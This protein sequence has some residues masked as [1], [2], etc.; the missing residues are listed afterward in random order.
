MFREITLELSLKPFKQNDTASMERICREL[1]SA[2]APLLR[3][4]EA[5]SVMLWAS[6]GSEI[7]DYAG[8]MDTPF[9]WCQYMG[10]ANLPDLKEGEPKYTSL[11]SRRQLYTENPPVFTYGILRE[12]VAILKR[13]GKRAFPEAHITVGETFDIGPEFAESD[14][15]Y[16]RH[17]EICSGTRLDGFGFVDATAILSPDTTRYA[18][19]PHGIPEGTCFGTFL[20]RQS[21][22]FLRDMGFDY[23]WLSNGLGFS[24]NPWDFTG[25]IYDGKQYYP[26]K[27]SD[28][29]ERVFR[30]WTLFRDACSYPLRVRGTNNTAG[31]DYATDGVPLHDIYAAGLDITPPPNSPWA[32]INDNFGLEMVGHMTRI[33]E[34]PGEDFMFRYYLHDPWWVNSPWYDRYDGAPTDIYLPMAVTRIREDGGVQGAERLQILSVDN[35]YGG[36]PACTVNEVIPH[37]LKAEKDLPDAPA[38][39]VLVYPMRQF[40]ESADG[41]LLREMNEGDHFL[42]DAVNDGLPL[43]CTVSAD[44]FARQDPMLYRASVLLA[45]AYVGEAAERALSVA[46]RAGIGVI[47]YGSEGMLSAL[48]CEK[49]TRVSFAAG[50]GGLLSAIGAFGYEIRYAAKAPEVKV[51]TVAVSR[52]D[53]A[54]H[55]SVYNSNT[56]TDTYLHFP[57]GAPILNLGETELWE[58]ASSYRFA[59]GEHRECRVFIEQP[60]GVIS[61]KEGPPVSA[62]FRRK[63]VIRGLQDATVCLFPEVGCKAAVADGNHGRDFITD[64]LPGFEEVH[65]PV[66]GTYLRGEHVTGCIYFLMER[67]GTAEP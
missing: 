64:L 35:S 67:R 47:R 15:K 61:C 11:H 44:I 7:L 27:L 52:C 24:A 23:L 19:Y 29:R 14:F 4:R 57:L 50:R 58:G 56:T 6:D 10:G 21:E 40:T 31:I 36:M 2:W 26:E 33:C 37:L 42:C 43:N 63:L 48:S 59:R 5:I 46:A 34:I 41:A 66:Y 38:P 20:G 65:D 17:R 8:D 13:E 54:Y 62:Q 32:A 55:F 28:T 12:L 9:A 3:D 53:G 18:A 25:K 49:Q 16:V 45:P 51:P 30:F 22:L 39:L 1:F 60:F